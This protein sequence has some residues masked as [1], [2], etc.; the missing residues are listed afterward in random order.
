MKPQ[1]NV[2]QS[3]NF[4]ETN[5]DVVD[6]FIPRPSLRLKNNSGSKI[7]G[8]GDTWIEMKVVRCKGKRGGVNKHKQ[9]SY[10]ETRSLFY[11]INTSRAFWDEPPTGASH[12]ISSIS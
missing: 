1:I 9:K 3:T 4:K 11:S 10:E 5:S 6:G 7:K 12:V 8:D 2:T